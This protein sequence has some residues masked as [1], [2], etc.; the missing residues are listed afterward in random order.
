M[1]TKLSIVILLSCLAFAFS[2][3]QSSFG[4]QQQNE[5][6]DSLLTSV[7]FLKLGF[8]NFDTLSL[9]QGMEEL[10]NLRNKYAE[11]D[12]LDLKVAETLSKCQALEMNYDMLT[13]TRDNLKFDLEKQQKQLN[14]LKQEI[15]L[16]AINQEKII[17]AISHEMVANKQ[18]Q[19]GLE[20]YKK[21]Y[22]ELSLNHNNLKPEINKLSLEPVN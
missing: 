17:E 6:I 9:K 21:K 18:I 14:L 8:V 10:H 20:E 7:R 1:K 3:C 2:N 4:N 16:G 15:K 19:K 22:F 11:K 12:T 13:F 5:K